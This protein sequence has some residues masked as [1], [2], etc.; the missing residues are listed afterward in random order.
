MRIVG[1]TGGIGA[2][3]SAASEMFRRHGAEVIDVDGLGRDVLEPGGGAYEAVIT[4]FGE[5]IV[6]PGGQIDRAALAGIVFADRE[7]LDALEAI[8]HPATRAGPWS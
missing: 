1:L 5:R 7:D 2:G 3:K 4:R 8:S 6:A